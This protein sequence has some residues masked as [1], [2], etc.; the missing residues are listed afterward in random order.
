MA[1][2]STYSQ[3]RI[4]KKLGESNLQLHLEK[5]KVDPSVDVSKEIQ[6]WAENISV[7][8]ALQ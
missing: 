6:V 7:I 3:P 2:S 4:M 1:L 5:L 8:P